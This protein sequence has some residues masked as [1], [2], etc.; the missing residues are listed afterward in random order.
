MEDN[1]FPARDA[2]GARGT[3]INPGCPH[4][5]IE[6]LVRRGIALEDGLPFSLVRSECRRG[7]Q[8]FSLRLH[9]LGSLTNSGGHPPVLPRTLDPAS[10]PG[11]PYL[12]FNLDDRIEPAESLWAGAGTDQS[13]RLASA[14]K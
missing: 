2:G 1:V 5:I 14:L 4:R 8:N 10:S 3:A 13:L 6:L 12:A 11:T 9:G 7:I